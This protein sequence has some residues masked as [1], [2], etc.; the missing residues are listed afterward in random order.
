MDRR[1]A[2]R[3][4][5]DAGRELAEHLLTYSG[6][7]A[8]VLGIPRGGLPVAVEVAS[9]L[10]ADLDIVVAR[11]LGAPDQPELAVGAVTS[12]GGRFL[13]RDVLRAVG[14]SEAELEAVTKRE[15]AEAR[16]REERFREGRPPA[17]LEGRVVLVVDDGLATGATMRASVRALRKSSP[18]RLVVAVPVGSEEACEALRAEADEVV[19]PWVPGFFGAVGFFYENFEPTEDDEVRDILREYSE[20][21][22]ASKKASPAPME[23]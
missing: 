14:I 15:M 17:P 19:C 16:R 23:A 12:D 7:G 18:A 5:R 2:Y 21:R 13:N 20:R 9:R 4:R 1:T 11:K 8:L 3:D 22:S 10:D 6:R